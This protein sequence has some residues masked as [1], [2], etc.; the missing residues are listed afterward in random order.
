M[1]Q[2]NI[3]LIQENWEEKHL[4]ISG[5][6]YETKKDTKQKIRMQILSNPKFLKPFRNFVYELSISYGIVPK[7]SFELKIIASEAVSNIIK[8]SYEN[9]SSGWIFFEYLFYNTYVEM[10]FRDFGKKNFNPKELIPKDLSEIRDRGLGL[11]VISKMSDYHY[12][13]HIEDLGTLL[14]IK[15]RI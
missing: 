11:Y 3:D 12:F 2:L 6:D 9:D 14:V 13:K 10:R 8:H 7:I 5:F 4:L 1:N 15:K